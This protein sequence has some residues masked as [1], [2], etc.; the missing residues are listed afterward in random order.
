MVKL[1]DYSGVAESLNRRIV[2]GCNWWSCRIVE[3][4][5]GGMRVGGVVE[6][7]VE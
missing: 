4:S 6:Y 1:V 3:S 5:N 2:K 7:I